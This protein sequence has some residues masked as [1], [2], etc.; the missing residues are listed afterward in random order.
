[1]RRTG[2]SIRRGDAIYIIETDKTTLE[3]ESP[4]DGRIMSWRVAPGD[5]VPIGAAVAVIGDDRSER[6]IEAKPD[7]GSRLIPPRTRAYAKSKG[8]SD[9]TLKKIPSATEKLLPAD[10]DAYLVA[11]T[12]ATTSAGY[13]EYKISG[14][15]RT[16]VYRLRRSAALVVPGTVSIELRWSSLTLPPISAAADVRATPFQVLCH[17]VAMAARVHPRFRS[18]IISDDTIREYDQVN[19]GIALARPKDE[20][21]TA[22]IRGADRLTLRDFVRACSRQMRSALRDGDQV[23]DDTQILMSHIGEYGI[24]DAV[25]TL[26]A[27]ASAVIF[28]SAP[29]LD[30][31]LVRICMTFDHRVMNG[32]SAGS[33]L[34]EVRRTLT[35]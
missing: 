4:H 19:L 9:D 20:L 22:V 16:L 5:V 6:R 8:L 25:P 3:L 7:D 26:V 12:F 27:P 31:D 10:I 29:K 2:D 21:L 11:P 35:A 1:M 28:L 15:H 13:R 18:V 17:A 33:L 30:S 23:R 32:A 34:Q 24:V 14:G